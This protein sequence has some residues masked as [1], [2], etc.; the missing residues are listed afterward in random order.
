M[1]EHAFLKGAGTWTLLAPKYLTSVVGTTLG[2]YHS[3]TWT[4]RAFDMVEQVFRVE[5]LIGLYT[6]SLPRTQPRVR[7]L[8]LPPSNFRTWGS[9]MSG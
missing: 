1:A 9:G 8:Q 4:L 3:G 2:I 7:L 6:R 5:G